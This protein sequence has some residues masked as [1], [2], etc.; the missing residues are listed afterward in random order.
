VNGA[1]FRKGLVTVLIVKELNQTSTYY[2]SRRGKFIKQL[3][4]CEAGDDS[5][6]IT[7]RALPSAHIR[8]RINGPHGGAGIPSLYVKGQITHVKD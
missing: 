7:A 3:D 4:E 6:F 2:L 5:R 8:I 1:Y